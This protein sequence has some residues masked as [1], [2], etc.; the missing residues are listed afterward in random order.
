MGKGAIN[1]FP[2]KLP[3]TLLAEC[4]VEISNLPKNNF[5]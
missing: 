4:T 2:I 3:A 1:N 5:L